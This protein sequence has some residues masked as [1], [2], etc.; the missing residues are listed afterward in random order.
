MIRVFLLCAL[1][2]TAQAGAGP[3]HPEPALAIPDVAAVPPRPITARD[4]AELRDIDTFT[5]SPDGRHVAFQLRRAV[6]EENR[7]RIAWFVASASP[8]TAAINVGDGGEPQLFTLSNGH[9]NGELASAPAKWS[10]DGGWIAYTV[11][12]DGAVQL[13]R[14][15]TD[16]GR[17]EQLT[18][19]DGDVRGF[20]W[21]AH[22]DRLY[23]TASAESRADER[24]RLD[25]EGERGYLL[26]GR[27]APG[28]S[29]RPVYRTP[30]PEQRHGIRALAQGEGDVETRL[31]VY[32]PGSGTTRPA[33]END[34]RDYARLREA[35]QPHLDAD[36][37]ADSLSL[38][39][40]A[41]IA[42]S[43]DGSRVAWLDVVSPDSRATYPDFRVFAT[44]PTAGAVACAEAACTGQITGLW[45][46][47]HD[48][49]V[50]EKH[51]RARGSSRTFYAW[52]PAS[53]R[54]RT[55]LSTDDAFEDCAAAGDRLICLYE[56]PTTPRRIAAMSLADGRLETLVDPNPEFRNIRFGEIELLDLSN[57]FGHAAFGH[58]LKPLD[59]VP[60]RRYPLVVVSYRSRGFLRGGVGDEYPAQL[61]A[62]HG[63]AVLSFDRP[64]AFLYVD[65]GQDM[66][67]I[68]RKEGEDFLGY[69]SV[70]A[71]LERGLAALET[72]GLI[73]PD[74]IALTGLSAGASMVY[75]ALVHS[76][77]PFAAAIASYA[78]GD[79]IGFYVGPGPWRAS[80]AS[81]IGG[82]PDGGGREHFE[83]VSP[84]QNAAR[85]DTPILMN[86]ADSELILSMQT[87][88]TLE[89]LG[90]PIETHV[91][92]DEYHVKRHP[93]HRYAIYRR[94]Q[95][96][97]EFWLR[98]ETESDPVDPGQY[99]RW[100]AL[101]RAYVAGLN[102]S[103]RPGDRE[104]AA[105]QRCLDA[106][107]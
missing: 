92:P 76:E 83:H 54:V 8:G 2:L 26:D 59:Y 10:P 41:L 22:G 11:L 37:F 81:R 91:F 77:R 48:E 15:R 80:V 57:E 73:D 38:T 105:R 90:K 31:W 25:R 61:L 74:R 27:F 94:N 104:R 55:I 106:A 51:T 87:I 68:A 82:L 101:C 7:Y 9:R 63:F 72:S 30:E 13:W 47:G 62:A 17:Q 14:S 44:A 53:G 60:G 12:Q 95:Q 39:N 96:W 100:T 52:S 23:V 64:D 98:G 40:P 79:P 93:A 29:T 18:R 86:V 99:G 49:L 58:V 3:A 43:A 85:I 103:D 20:E 71:S 69:R 84:A 56:S 19:L 102:S 67:S 65:A 16:G 107:D 50:F 21:S 42:R 34:E 5:V 75:Y 78:P 97:L 32:D 24:R 6:P 36:R 33:S 1:S 46:S 89:Y 35:R 70:E 45:W 28:G 4:L 88:A 66:A